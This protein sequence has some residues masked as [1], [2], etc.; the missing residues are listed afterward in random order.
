MYEIAKPPPHASFP[1]IQPTTRFSEIRHG[2]EFAVDGPRGV[3]ARVEC[4]TGFLRGVFVLEARVDVADEMIVIII[5]N[6]HL[7]RLAIFTHFAPKVFVESVEVVLEL[8]RVHLCFGI[9][10]GV[11]VEVGEEDGLAVGGLDVFAGAAVAVAAGAD[12]VVETAVYF[13]L[14]CA[15]DGGEVVGHY[16]V[17][18]EDLGYVVELCC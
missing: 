2:T 9:V 8:R 5:T 13:V 12:F 16:D 14:F 17:R 11:L 1:A 10:G 4:V 6:H 18:V 7:L 15:E 3:P